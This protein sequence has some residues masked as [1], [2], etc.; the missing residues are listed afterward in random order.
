[1]KYAENNRIS[2]RQLYRQ[3]ILSVLAPFLLCIPEREGLSGLSGVTGIAIAI[4]FLLLYV[5]L[6]MRTSYCYADP[7]KILG[8]LKGGILGIF[9]LLYLIMTAVYILGL[10]AQIVPV[11]A[12]SEISGS[13]LTLWAVVVCAYG[14][15]R[16][17]Q[18]RGRMA[19]VSG[20]IFLFLVLLMLL[21]CI[22]QGKS[23]R[24]AA[25]ES[26]VCKSGV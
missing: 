1:M 23:E 26:T 2:H 15:D 5:F 3:I 7:V 12:V 24:N 4:L 8:K 6:L 20:G 9:F 21:L 25:D 13:W 18:R 14:A 17:M 19:D 22:G 11:W 10:I 16:G